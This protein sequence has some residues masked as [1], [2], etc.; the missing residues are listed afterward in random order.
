MRI[1]GSLRDCGVGSELSDQFYEE[2]GEERLPFEGVYAADD[3]CRR[4]CS[5]GGDEWQSVLMFLA[6]E[7]KPKDLDLI[8]TRAEK[9]AS[10]NKIKIK[11]FE[12]IEL[13]VEYQETSWPWTSAQD[14]E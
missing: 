14:V 4:P 3:N 8:R 5:M 6:H 11:R 7:P 13:R 9:Y 2:V 10:Q 12:L 1:A